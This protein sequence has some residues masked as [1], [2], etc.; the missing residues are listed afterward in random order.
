MKLFA[1]R[2]ARNIPYGDSTAF[3]VANSVEEAWEILKKSG[4]SK[5]GYAP[6]SGT[7][8]DLTGKDPDWS[9]DVPCGFFYEWSE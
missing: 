6:D 2:N 5:Y 4:I 9:M 1:W 3:A 8:V 7:V